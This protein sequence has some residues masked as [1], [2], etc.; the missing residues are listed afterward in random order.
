MDHSGLL[1][2]SGW[3]KMKSPKPCLEIDSFKINK[4]IV[5]PNFID[6]AT[7]LRG[8]RD[9]GQSVRIHKNTNQP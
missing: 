1:D 5:G 2:K 9:K 6:R 8:S 7:F 3:A 4:I